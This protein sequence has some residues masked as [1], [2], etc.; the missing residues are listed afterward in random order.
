MRRTLETGQPGLHGFKSV[1][2]YFYLTTNDGKPTRWIGYDGVMSEWIKLKAKDGHELSAYI[3]QPIGE[4]VG[5]LILVQE[6]FGVNAHIRSVADGYAKDGFLVVAPGIFDRF[7]PGVDLT[8][9]PEDMKRAYNFYGMLKPE[10]T[11]MDV[12]AAY[13]WAKQ[14]G[15]KIGVIGYCYGGLTS[16]LVATRGKDYGMQPSCCV[17]YYAGGIGSVAKE[18]PSCPVMLHFG[19]N[20]SHIGKDQVDAVRSAHPDV[21]IFVYEGAGHAF[22]RDVDPSSYH[23]ASAKLARERSVEFLK[24]HLA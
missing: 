7:E 2:F 21:E 16:W 19:A 6:I 10:T 4:A 13:A 11:L 23:A 9:Q 8:Y 22:N 15:K 18:E 3:A 24:T 12:A 17:G 20:D 5:V 14:A 1:T